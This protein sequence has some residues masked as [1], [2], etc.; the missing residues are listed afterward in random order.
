MKK[1]RE[2][3][4][5]NPTDPAITPG[6]HDWNVFVARKLKFNFLSSVERFVFLEE[7]WMVVKI[8]VSSE[9]GVRQCV[10]GSGG[11]PAQ[12][13][14]GCARKGSPTTEGVFPG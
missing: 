8:S 14:R 1:F 2:N 9:G 11:G 3:F 5:F 6:K 7:G 4:K 13:V 12:G 10:W